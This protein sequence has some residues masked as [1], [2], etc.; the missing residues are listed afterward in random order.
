MKNKSAK[1]KS[2]K[3]IEKVKK[4]KKCIVDQSEFSVGEQ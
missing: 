3:K 2:K 4:K 1:K